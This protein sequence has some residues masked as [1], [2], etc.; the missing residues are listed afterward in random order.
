MFIHA[1][2]VRA[3][4]SSG[5]ATQNRQGFACVSRLFQLQDLLWRACRVV[6]DVALQCGRMS[7]EEAAAYLETEAQLERPVAEA[8]VRRYVLT[9]TEPMSYLIGKSLLLELRSEAAR[10]LG[11]RFDLYRFHEHLLTCGTVSPTLVKDEL[12][13]RLGVG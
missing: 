8:E 11:D 9:P 4:F 10:A 3:P 5:A 6:L 1:I 7:L 2:A 12:W 13:V